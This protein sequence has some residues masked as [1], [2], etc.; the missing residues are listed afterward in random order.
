MNPSKDILMPILSDMICPVCKEALLR[1]DPDHRHTDDK[2][3]VC[4]NNDCHTHFRKVGEELVGG[5]LSKH[6]KI[7][8][9]SYDKFVDMSKEFFGRFNDELEE[10]EEREYREWRENSKEYIV[11]YLREELGITQD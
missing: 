3:F 11:R 8:H 4:T 5:Y 1:E 7:K 6:H 2:H 9:V 10:Q